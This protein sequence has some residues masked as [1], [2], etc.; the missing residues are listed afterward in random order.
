MDAD[1]LETAACIDLFNRRT[2]PNAHKQARY[3]IWIL[4][5]E[6]CGAFFEETAAAL[7]ALADRITLEVLCGGLSEELYKMHV[8][9]DTA[10]PKEFPRK[11]TRMWLSNVP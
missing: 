11:Y 6:A 4:A 3:S 10:R 7:K 8:K 9:A 1:V 2:G 5:S